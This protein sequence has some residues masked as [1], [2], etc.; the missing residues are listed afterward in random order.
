MSFELVSL[1]CMDRWSGVL[2]LFTGMVTIP[3][4]LVAGMIWRHVG[5][6]YVFVIPIALDLLLRIP[7]LRTIPE[8]LWRQDGRR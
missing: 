8:T 2:G 4:P 7:L 1:Q 5:P 3:A 6:A